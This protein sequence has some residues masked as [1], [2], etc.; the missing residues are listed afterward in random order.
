MRLEVY[1]IGGIRNIPVHVL[2][3]HLRIGLG[4]L[5]LLIAGVTT[6]SKRYQTD[7]DHDLFHINILVSK[8]RIYNQWYNYYRIKTVDQDD[9]I[10]YSSIVKVLISNRHQEIII[11][12]NPVIG[13]VISVQLHDMPAGKYSMMLLNNQGQKLVDEVLEHSGGSRTALITFDESLPHGI[14]QLQV[15]K[16]DHK[17]ITT[18]LIR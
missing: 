7:N 13:H 4:L 17:R 14:Y 2:Y 15:I 16:P 10:S 12:P 6:V 5:F 11:Y 8:L 18:K 1:S 3:S 9:K